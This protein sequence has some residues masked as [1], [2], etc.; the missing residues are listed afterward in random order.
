MYHME[1][2][3]RPTATTKQ[4]KVG[5]Q[6]K[7]ER[8][9]RQYQLNITRLLVWFQLKGNDLNKNC[10]VCTDYAMLV[11]CLISHRTF[12]VFFSPKIK[13]NLKQLYP[14]M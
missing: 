8:H 1:R 9:Q 3:Y 4:Q 14:Y 2:K 10:S 11:L 13:S 7:V 6:T 5:K 12:K